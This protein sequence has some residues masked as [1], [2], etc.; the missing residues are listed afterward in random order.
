MADFI[1]RVK[2]ARLTGARQKQ[3]ATAIQGTVLAGLAELDLR[4]EA[5]GPEV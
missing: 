5:S 3:I 4:A 1:F 2:S